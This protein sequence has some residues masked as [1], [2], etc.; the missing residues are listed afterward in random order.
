MNLGQMGLDLGQM[1]LDPWAEAAEPKVMGLGLAYG[2][3]SMGPLA[4]LQNPGDSPLEPRLP[5]SGFRR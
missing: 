2:P 4:Q 1:G 5:A 3:R